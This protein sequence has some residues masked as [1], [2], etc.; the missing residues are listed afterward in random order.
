M[1]TMKVPGVPLIGQKNDYSCWYA[2][3]QM[4]Y[5]YSAANGGS[6]LDPASVSMTKN[7]ASGPTGGTWDSTNSRLLASTLNMSPWGMSSVSLDYDCLWYI[8]SA[9]GPIWTSLQKNWGGNNYGHVVVITGI[10]DGAAGG[11]RIYDPMPMTA[12]SKIWLTWSQ[13]KKAVDGQSEA[14]YHYL[15]PQ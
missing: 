5:A 15:T 12:G 1:A 10:R 6:M 4:L 7:R 8:L 3:S 14:D 13:I 9:F 11:V 2:S